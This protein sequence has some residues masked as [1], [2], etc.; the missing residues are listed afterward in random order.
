MRREV[1]LP[2]LGEGVTEGVVVRWL[3]QRGDTVRRDQ[4]VVEV[5]TDKAIVDLPSPIAGVVLDLA[6]EIGD[7]VPVGRALLVVED[8]QPAPVPEVGA[9]PSGGSRARAMPRVRQLAKELGVD[10]DQLSALGEQVTERQV[11]EAAG[12]NGGDAEGR[13]S[14]PG[15]RGAPLPATRRRIAERLTAAHQE[16]PAVTIVEECDFTDVRADLPAPSL[17]AFALAAVA[18]TLRE[19]PAL[20][21]TFRDGRLQHEARCDI[22]LA[23]RTERGLL[24]PVVRR[25]DELSCQ[26]LHDEV[27]RL[28][29][30]ARE[31]T[32]RAEELRGSTFTVTSAGRLGGLFATP[33]VNA[34]EVAI[35]GLHRIAPRPAVYEGELAIREIGLVSCTF[36]HRVLDGDQATEFLLAAIERLS[37]PCLPTPQPV[38]AGSS[39]RQA[40]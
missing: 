35:L 4:P 26:E 40:G 16:V 14:W 6:A 8:E 31:G 22:G 13:S 19:H 23:V 25:A 27:R 30:G 24:V 10:L 28:A 15:E 21:A 18:R 37:S 20:N 7:V 1:R 17:V 32:L 11:R 36:D 12:H 9:G 34:P 39:S 33:I 3:V 38:R 2:D 29:E 5:E